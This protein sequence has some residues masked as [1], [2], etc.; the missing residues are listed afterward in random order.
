LIVVPE[1]PKWLY[2]WEHFEESKEVLTYV[3]KSN[4]LPENK[5][6]RIKALTFDLEQ[7]EK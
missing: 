2:T 1:S 4:S 6:N 5:I 3:G 7:L